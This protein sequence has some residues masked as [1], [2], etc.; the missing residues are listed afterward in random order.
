LNVI[1]FKT[2]HLEPLTQFPP[3]TSLVLGAAM[4]FL[5]DTTA[6]RYLNIICFISLGIIIWLMAFSLYEGQ[7]AYMVSGTLAVLTSTGMLWT[8]SYLLSEPLYLLFGFAGLGLLISG[9]S[10]KTSR[11]KIIAWSLLTFSAMTRLSGL[12]FLAAGACLFMSM[13]SGRLIPRMAAGFVFAAA[14]T[15]PLL[16]WQ[17][18]V[19]GVTG[20]LRVINPVAWADRLHEMWTTFGL[21]I[22]PD[23]APLFVKWLAA[24]GVAFCLGLVLVRVGPKV[25]MGLW[26]RQPMSG[27]ESV[28]FVMGAFLL[29]YLGLLILSTSLLGEPW[30]FGFRILVPMQIPL[31][32]LSIYYLKERVDRTGFARLNTRCLLVAALFIVLSSLRSYQ[33]AKIFSAIGIET[34]GRRYAE[35]PTLQAVARWEGVVYANNPRAVWYQLRRPVRDARGLRGEV[36]AGACYVHL[37]GETFAYTNHAA[38]MTETGF[39]DG[40]IIQHTQEAAPREHQ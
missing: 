10:Q 24:L 33:R 14:G 21:W 9:R 34:S 15:L 6:A 17:W 32:L 19:R 20:V 5:P 3:G 29:S 13:S 30:P 22:V 18:H 36:P 26:H 39:T 25:F 28:R 1:S 31:Y 12:A 11:I 7:V 35:S 4:S 40:Y 16:L 2:G 37:N 38:R 8:Y 27:A 23:Q